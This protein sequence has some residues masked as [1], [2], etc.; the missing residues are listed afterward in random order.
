MNDVLD[1]CFTY[2]KLLGERLSCAIASRV[3]AANLND[4]PLCEFG[5]SC[6]FAAWRTFWVGVLAVAFTACCAFGMLVKSVTTLLRHVL[7][8]IFGRAS[9][10]MFWIRAGRIVAMMANKIPIRNWAN[11]HFIRQAVSRN[12]SANSFVVN[13]AISIGG[14]ASSPFP[15][16]VSFNN[17]LPKAFLDRSFA[18]VVSALVTTEFDYL[19]ARGKPSAAFGT[20]NL[21]RGIMGLHRNSPFFAKPGTFTRR[22]QALSIGGYYRSNYSMDERI[23]QAQ[24]TLSGAAATYLDQAVS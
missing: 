1:R 6:I 20:L 24:R 5:L 15:T 17:V 13:Q 22:C 10:E 8:V 11:V 9:K 12:F 14:C 3:K 19:A 7:T 18:A 16:S 21:L 23:T 2:P 4:L